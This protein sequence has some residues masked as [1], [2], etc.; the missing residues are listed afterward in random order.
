MPSLP[1]WPSTMGRRPCPAGHVRQEPHLQ[2][3]R[4]GRLPLRRTLELI[5][6]GLLDYDAPSQRSYPLREIEAAY[7]LL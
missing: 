6:Q 7:E 1:S 5:A 2:D 4:R 3:R